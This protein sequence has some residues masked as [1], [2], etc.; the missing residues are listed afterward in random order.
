MHSHT[1]TVISAAVYA[2]VTGR[3]AAGLFDHAANS[4]V[5][6]AAECRDGRVQG[7]DGE[8]S[9]SF[10]GTL[11]DLYDQ[12]DQA[13]ITCDIDGTTGR[14]FDHGSA[15]FYE[16]RVSGASVSLYDHGAAAWFSYTVTSV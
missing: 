7:R 6:V 14:G 3:K 13:F 15:S 1:R 2:I 9:V 5:R 10:G 16:A 11:P 4:H 12:G 8:R